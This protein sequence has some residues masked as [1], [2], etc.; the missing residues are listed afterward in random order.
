MHRNL[1][2]EKFI[3][4]IP[5]RYGTCTCTEN[6]TL[7]K[8]NSKCEILHLS[9]YLVH[10]QA[11][12]Q[13]SAAQMPG[14][15]YILTVSTEEGL[16][17]LVESA[18]KSLL[19]CEPYVTTLEDVLSCAKRHPRRITLFTQLIYKI[20]S[21]TSKVMNFNYLNCVNCAVLITRKVQELPYFFLNGSKLKR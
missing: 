6:L 1:L 8:G 10:L 17:K 15:S 4:R 3:H 20:S 14:F 2:C 9:D 7:F 18:T 13:V 21:D 16:I 19:F 11:A 5:K 12:T